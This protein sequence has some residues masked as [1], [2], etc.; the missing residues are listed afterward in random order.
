MKKLCTDI[1]KICMVRFMTYLRNGNNKSWSH[2]FIDS[3]WHCSRWSVEGFVFCRNNT[4][5]QEGN[6]QICIINIVNFK[7]INILYASFNY[8]YSHVFVK[9]SLQHKKLFYYIS[10]RISTYMKLFSVHQKHDL[11]FSH[12][13]L[14][15]MQN[16]F[17]FYNCIPFL[18][19][20]L[21][22]V[23]SYWSNTSTAYVKLSLKKTL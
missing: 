21:Q 6:M 3:W 23:K 8:S 9:N 5:R 17:T 14:C 10:N 19:L 13:S 2:Q 7:H 22:H 16:V 20:L 1:Q 11:N 15:D 4:N 12:N 18:V